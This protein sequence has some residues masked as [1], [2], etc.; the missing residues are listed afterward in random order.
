[1][2]PAQVIEAAQNNLNAVTDDLWSQ[3]ELLT[4]LYLCEQ[5]LARK[6]RC[7]ESVDETLLTQSGTATYTIPSYIMDVL[8]VV[9]NDSQKLQR[10]TL[11][12]NDTLNPTGASQIGTPAYYSVFN[13]AI[14]LYPTPD[15]DNL[16]I[17]IWSYNE[18]VKA[19]I[20]ATL[21]TPPRYH[22]ALVHGLT[23]S[24]C[25][26]DLGHPLV[27]FWGERWL[28]SIEEVKTHVKLRRRADGFAMVV[29][30]EDALTTNFGII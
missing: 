23:F 22:D 25:P 6:T 12:E 1:M 26:K 17:K 19:I 2:T 16:A 9:Y 18:P 13:E 5:E 21:S 27:L 29:R 30:E 3:E 7:I 20:S 8:R 15:T 14:T 11:G 10:I 28:R 4:S 24:M